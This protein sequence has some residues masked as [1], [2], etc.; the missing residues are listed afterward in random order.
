MRR[1]PACLSRL[2]TCEVAFFASQGSICSSEL[3]AGTRASLH[4]A[5]YA[6]RCARSL[7]P[8]RGYEN[9]SSSTSNRSVALGGMTCAP[10]APLRARI[11]HAPAQH[12]PCSRTYLGAAGVACGQPRCSKQAGPAPSRRSQTMRELGAHPGRALRAV[13][14][15]RRDRQLR[16]LAL[17]LRVRAPEARQAGLVAPPLPSIS[18]AHHPLPKARRSTPAN[19][20][21]ALTGRMKH[22]ATQG[23]FLQGSACDQGKPSSQPCSADQGGKNRRTI[24]ATPSSQPLPPRNFRSQSPH[25]CSSCLQHT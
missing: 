21:E 3:H 10:P 9:D 18:M 4:V 1:Q 20:T 22:R 23:F 11:C 5:G 13:A 24:L 17:G 19:S 12:L 7:Q 25:R 16:L 15:V 6:L 2:Q 8:G 14:V